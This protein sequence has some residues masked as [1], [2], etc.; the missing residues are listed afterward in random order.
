MQTRFAALA[1]LGL[2]GHGAKGYDAIEAA[3][4]AVCSSK[5]ARSVRVTLLRNSSPPSVLQ[6]KVASRAGP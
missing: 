4:I 3:R 6:E 5:G 1:G 2:D